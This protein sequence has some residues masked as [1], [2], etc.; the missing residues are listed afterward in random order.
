VANTPSSGGK[1]QTHI[2][3]A[4][5]SNSI[6][7]SS[8]IGI[9]QGLWGSK[10][11]E[12]VIEFE[13]RFHIEPPKVKVSAKMKKAREAAASMEIST[14]MLVPCPLPSF[15]ALH[16]SLTRYLF[17]TNR[18][19]KDQEEDNDKD[20]D[21][22]KILIKVHGLISKFAP[23]DGRAGTDRQFFYVNGRPCALGKVSYS[24]SPL[25]AVVVASSSIVLPD[26]T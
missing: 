24:S 6:S 21:K 16:A 22:D 23:G 7:T 14:S 3:S 11:L 18:D 12:G 20:K 8:L 13:L 1:K 10:S 19:D 9:A 5:G 26:L 4:G 2:L 17:T 15:S 25:I